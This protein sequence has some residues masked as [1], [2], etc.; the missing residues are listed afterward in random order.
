M[1]DGFCYDLILWD[2]D[3]MPEIIDENRK[4]GCSGCDDGRKVRK[5]T[6]RN[7]FT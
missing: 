2:A 7:L 3:A 1:V 5:V 6:S 4:H